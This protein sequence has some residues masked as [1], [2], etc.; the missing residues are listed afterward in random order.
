MQPNDRRPASRAR[1]SSR[2]LAYLTLLLC[3]LFVIPASPSAA[4][5][6]STEPSASE[7]SASESTVQTT[8]DEGVIQAAGNLGP[9]PVARADAYSVTQDKTRSVS[10]PGVL[11]NDSKRR[12]LIVRFVLGPRV[13]VAQDHTLRV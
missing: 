12:P 9:L 7:P 3:L 5:Q 13:A 4:Q 11:A 6:A 1:P 2:T 10:K 8:E